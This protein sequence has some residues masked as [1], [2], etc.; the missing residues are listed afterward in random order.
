LAKQKRI[1]YAFLEMVTLSL[2]DLGV[3]LIELDRGGHR[4]LPSRVPE[5]APAIN[6][7]KYLQNELKQGSI[8]RTFTAS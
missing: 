6:P 8:S 5:G 2:A 4:L 7:K 3:I 1:R